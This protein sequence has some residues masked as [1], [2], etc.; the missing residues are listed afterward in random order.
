M[1]SRFSMRY[2]YTPIP[3]VIG[4]KCL[5]LTCIALLWWIGL[6]IIIAPGFSQ[7]P[8]KA[9]RRTGL[10]ISNDWNNPSS[11]K[12]LSEAS[13]LKWGDLAPDFLLRDSLNRKFRLRKFKD[14]DLLILIFSHYACP[15][16]HLYQPKIMALQPMW[17]R[18]HG[19][20]L[21]I[22]PHSLNA[23]MIPHAETVLLQ[24]LHGEAF[25]AYGIRKIPHVLVLKKSNSFSNKQQRTKWKICYSGAVDADPEN[26]KSTMRADLAEALND[27]EF[28]DYVRIPQTPLHGCPYPY[29]SQP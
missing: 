2:R 28:S 25:A 26:P 21:W 7:A 20:A 23:P 16:H 1:P 17:Q 15:A 22:Y 9:Q 4:R 13:T 19:K 27:L 14:Q 24:D 3:T 29:S 5:R 11:A 6:P 12:D 18:L 8:N 10:S